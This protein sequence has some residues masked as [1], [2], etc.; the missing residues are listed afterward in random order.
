MP[1]TFS[2]SFEF[3]GL[4]FRPE[5]NRLETNEKTETLPPHL[6]LF[7]LCLVEKP[8][9]F[10][11]YE[12]L[13][14][15]IWKN[16]KE[17]DES[18][19]HNIHVTKANLV[20]MLKNL[21]FDTK[22]LNYSSGKG[23]ALNVEVVQ[24]SDSENI[25]QAEIHPEQIALLPTAETN[26]RKN[27][28]SQYILFALL[29]SIFYGLLYSIALVLEIAYQFDRYGKKA[30]WLGVPLIFLNGGAMFAALSRNFRENRSSFW[31]GT[32]FLIGGAILSCVAAMFFLPSE[33]ITAARFQSQPA[34]AAFLKNAL[35][36][37]LPLGVFFVFTPFYLAKSGNGGKFLKL[38]P[39]LWG[40]L[41]LAFI[42]S[43]FSTFYLLDN[44]LPSPFHAT[45]VALC[46]LRFIVY[47]GLA[48]GCLLYAKSLL[49]IDVLPD[50]NLRRYRQTVFAFVLA[51]IGLGL[52]M[53][54]N[55]NFKSPQLRTVEFAA[56]PNQ[57]RQMFVNLSGENFES[58]T[59]CIRVAGVDCAEAA[60]CLVPHSALR[61]HSIIAKDSLQ[62]VPLTLPSGEFRLY[63]QN[64]D[65]P[66]SN[67][68]ILNV[69]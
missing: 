23:Y 68:I 50:F 13:R 48:L 54:A 28:F 5:T 9:E 4:C 19:K 32:G 3:G 27:S 49:E 15:N 18:V 34:F 39:N 22:L 43:L 46:F 11:S 62:N 51:S 63:A 30:L 21:E 26:Q 60:P 53:A 10:I 1:K 41:C 24:I 17:V 20:K 16:T 42:Y 8:F 56:L 2:R 40:I 12:E 37:F 44:L 14:Q 38:L 47:F 66:M 61:K 55:R 29:A 69:P 36:Y 31:I 35:I 67:A 7:L 64:G 6:S 58:E 45:F 25:N 52:V 33:P 65:S 59:V 57:E